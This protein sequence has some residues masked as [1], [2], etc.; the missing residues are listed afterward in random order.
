MTDKDIIDDT[1]RYLPWGLFM[2][3]LIWGSLIG[4]LSWKASRLNPINVELINLPSP[5]SQTI[6]PPTPVRQATRQQSSPEPQSSKQ[7]ASQTQS[8][9]VSTPAL[10]LSET[11]L[12]TNDKATS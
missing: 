8:P 10:A 11:N 7:S 5:T 3:L 9:T 2:A 1:W 6:V 12:P 4:Q